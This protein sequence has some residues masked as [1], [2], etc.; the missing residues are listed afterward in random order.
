[1]EAGLVAEGSSEVGLMAQV[2]EEWKVDMA[3]L[4]D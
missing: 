2:D 1:M 3:L 4:L